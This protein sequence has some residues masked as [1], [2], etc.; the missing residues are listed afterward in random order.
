MILIDHKKTDINNLAG[1]ERDSVVL[2]W[3]DRRK[4]R[5]RLRTTKGIEIAVALPTG[6]ILYN[7]DILYMNNNSYIIVEAAEE[8]VIVIYPDDMTKGA[9]I[10][11]EIGNRHLP[12]SINGDSIMTPYNH[13]L[14]EYLKKEAIQYGHKRDVFEP[15]KRGHSHG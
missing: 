3:E 13:V 6:T 12:I 5:Q 9:V 14:E 1:L 11:Y 8:D 10:A 2:N 4:S 7:G 15:V